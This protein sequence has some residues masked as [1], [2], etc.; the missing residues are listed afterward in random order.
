MADAAPAAPPNKPAPKHPR[1]PKPVERYGIIWQPSPAL[2]DITIELACYVN[3]LATGHP[4]EYHFKQAWLLT[5][6]KTVWNEWMDFM[7]WAWCNY[8]LICVIG[9]TR[10]S[11]TWFFAFAALLDYMAVPEKTA[12]TLTTTKFDALKSRMWGDMMQAFESVREEVRVQTHASFKVTNTTNELKV[13]INDPNVMGDDKFMIQ[14]VA[15]DSADTAAGK[16]RGQHADRRRIIGDEAQDIAAPIY[17]AFLNAMSAPDFKGVLLSNPVERLSEFGEWCKPKAGWSSVKDTDLFWETDKPG[18]ICLHF[19]GLQSPNIK[20]GRTIHPFMLT[21][22]YVDD[23]AAS[24]GRDSLEWWMYVRGFFPPDGVVARVW[25]SGTIEKARMD[26]VFD[27]PPT[28][29]GS[30]DPAYEQ[31]NPVL[32]LGLLGRL[33]TGIP[34]CLCKKQIVIKF[35]EGPGHPLKDRQ[36]ADETKK[37]CIEFGVQPENFIMDT[38]GNGRS[39]YALL[40][41]GWSQKIQKL[42]YGGEAT[43]RPIR[44][45]DKK[46]ANEEVKYF[47]AELWFRASFLAQAGMLCGFKNLH[48]HNEDD[49][50]SRRYTI[51]QYGE[52][53]LM[54]VEPKEDLK[55]RIGRSPDFGDSTCQL[56]ELM[57]RKGLLGDVARPAG[58]GGWDAL[59]KLARAAGKRSSEVV[60]QLHS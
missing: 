34:C 58:K 47:V 59:R 28:P 30:L 32:T 3:R 12:T 46:P 6:P 1:A 5:W 27:Y 42:E 54:A 50:T 56:G 29:V 16:I 44:L 49:L 39:V 17:L 60:H 9:H 7:V 21:Q 10:A 22:Q 25:P 48:P 15:T 41:E 11:K 19:D 45:N 20:A 38:S 35:K 23:I 37:E 26:C 51:K 55:K 4:P 8:R 43:N 13:Q 52:R 40:Y 36:L 31:D 33:R 57:A 53:K 24:K 2:N 14:G 18:G